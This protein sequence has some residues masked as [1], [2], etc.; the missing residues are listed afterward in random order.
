MKTIFF[1]AILSTTTM[2]SAQSQIINKSFIAQIGTVCEETSEPNPCAGYNIYL[3][4][5]FEKEYVTIIEKNIRTCKTEDTKFHL[6]TKWILNKNREV[7]FPDRD[8]LKNTFV[9]NL[10]LKVINNTLI[11]Y[12]PDWKKKI[13][14]YKFEIN[15]AK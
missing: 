5:N 1:V 11:G 8:K 9:E 12:K 7:I 4:L 15:R 3:L 10:S 6:K 2:F 13:Q 14:E